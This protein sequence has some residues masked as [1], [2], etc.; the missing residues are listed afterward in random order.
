MRLRVLLAELQHV[1]SIG[2]L[3]RQLEHQLLGVLGVILAGLG[4]VIVSLL[5]RDGDVLA[6][7]GIAVILTTLAW[8]LALFSA[9]AVTLTLRIMRASRYISRV[10][11]PRMEKLTGEPLLGW[12]STPSALLIGLDGPGRGG[13]VT[14]SR[15]A[16]LVFITSAPI[17]AG[18]GIG[19]LLSGSVAAW[20]WMTTSSLGPGGR[21]SG[22]LAAATAG[23]LSVIVG[24]W[25]YRL[26]AT[27][28][29]T[30]ESH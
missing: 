5:Q 26:A 25:G 23:I 22:S 30:R 2:P 18:L 10:L 12:E 27:T 14:R 3:Q 16:R 9:V 20:L 11:Y 21:I 13:E 19:G 4:S 1:S 8:I 24:A 28:D 15:R 29:R 6:G 17:L 7:P